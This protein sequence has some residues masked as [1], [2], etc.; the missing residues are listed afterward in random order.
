MFKKLIIIVSVILLF[1]SCSNSASKPTSNQ[2][3][4]TTPSTVDPY[5]LES[6]DTSKAIDISELPKLIAENKVKEGDIITFFCTIQYDHSCTP[7]SLKYI[8][9]NHYH[10][11]SIIIELSDSSS[12]LDIIILSQKVTALDIFLPERYPS[13]A[14]ESFLR[15]N[16]LKEGDNVVVKGK[17]YSKPIHY[18]I[19]ID[20]AIIE[21]IKK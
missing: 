6:I 9:E 1:C 10:Q 20:D 3:N 5:A 18:D 16:T 15:I 4:A 13:S 11:N 19:K 14:I 12:R 8:Y 21:K 17:Y 2:V 7:V